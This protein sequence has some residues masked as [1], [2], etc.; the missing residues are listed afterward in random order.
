MLSGTQIT[1]PI[2][3]TQTVWIYDA[4]ATC[5]NEKSF[6]V[7]VNHTP[8]IINPGPQT[9]CDSYTFPTITG[10]NLTGGQKFYNNSKALNGTVI[11]GPIT[12]TQTIWIYDE[13][14]LCH[15]EKSFIVT[16]NYT[17][18]ITNP[19][20]QTVCDSYTLPTITGTHLSGNQKFYNNT[21]A[22]GGTV[23]TGPI[24]TTQTIWIYDANASCS[25][26]ESFVVTVNHTPNIT[27]PG[28]IT[29]CDTYTLP[30]ITGI[31]LTGN[32]KF[33]SNS[34]ALSGTA[35][36]GPITSTQ[37]IWI[38]DIQG[39]CKDEKSF[40][41][42]VNYTPTIT[43]T[44]SQI[45]CDSYTLPT[46]TGTHLSGSQ[47]YY[48][49]SQALSGTV[50]T[51]PITTTQ[52]VWIYDNNGTCKDEKSFSI[53][54]NKTPNITQPQNITVCDSY[55]LPAILGTNLSGNEKYYNNSQTLGGVPISGAIITTQTVW[56]YD[57]N[58]ACKNEKS[59]T[60]SIDYTPNMFNTG[61]QIVCDSYTLPLITGTNLTGNQKY[62]S[63][64]QAL[65][66]TPITGPITSTQPVWI[67]DA[68]GACKDEKSFI[69]TVNYT[70]FI[71]NPGNQ[72]VCDSYTLNAITGAHLS[73]NQKYYNNSK[74]LGGT[75]ITGVLTNTQT[76]WMY[77]QNGTCTNEKSF[78]LTVY[79]TPSINNPGNITVCD[80]YMLPVITGT[81]LTGAQKFYT[82]SQANSGMPLSGSITSNQTVWIYD[83]DG[84]CFDEKSFIVTVNHTPLI[85]NP[86]NQTVCDSYTLPTITG[87]NLNGSQKYYNNSQTS[88]GTVITGPITTTQ[89]VWMYDI[90]GACKDEKSF[91]ITINKTPIFS[92]PGDQTVCDTY[93]LPSFI[94]TYLSGNQNYF[95]NSQTNGGLV[96]NGP[97][98][99]TQTIW[100]YDANAACKNE[101][102]FIITVNHTPSLIN[103]G[104][105]TVCDIY[106]LPTITG[107]NLS[108][109][110]KYYNNSNLLNGSPINGPITLTQTIWIY[111]AQGSCSDEK[112]FIIT[113]NHT[114]N[115]TNPGNIT[116]C[117]SYLLTPISGTNLTGNQKYFNNSQVLGGTPITGL[118]TTTQKVWMYD[119]DA[120]CKD[121]KSFDITVNI[122][123]TINFTPDKTKGCVPLT[124]KFKNSTTPSSDN[125]VWDFGDGNTF[126]SSQL[127]DE[128]THE[129]TTVDCF[130]IKL[131]VTS[132]GCTN[133]LKTKDLI[134]TYSIPKASFNVDQERVSFLSPEV[135]C[136][137]TT[138]SATSYN[139]Y[140]GDGTESKEIN[141][142]H[143][144][145]GEKGTMQIILIAKNSFGCA[146]TA[147]RKIEIYDELIFYIPNTFTPDEDKYN[148]VFTPIFNAGYDPQNFTMYVFD[149]WGEIV[150][151]T[152]DSSIGW[153]G[154]LGK[155]EKMKCQDGL[156]IWKISYKENKTG[157]TKTVVGDVIL[158]R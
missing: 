90:D 39:L 154:L 152:H 73:G 32:E 81:N 22:S 105:Q 4:N 157:N 30:T 140:F 150:F 19:G 69:V 147:E 27:N 109:N 143:E 18:S 141:P 60:V 104:N 79:H 21:Q 15:D 85:N 145:P 122:T 65:S 70:P 49:N 33:Y 63:N 77:D 12:T 35:I 6:L 72:T 31:N 87:T 41:V 61:A 58:G 113:V 133:F 37:T 149:R 135:K 125:V 67:Y 137:N 38:Y 117:D 64:S 44:G 71:N 158:M 114:P 80:S 36:L 50:I 124:V 40:V 102:S 142:T 59:F 24:T 155:E 88:G 94:G 25:D 8:S 68:D 126:T 51:G 29:V 45:A 55:T 131:T 97:I 53:T 99:Q 132:N 95:T 28:N 78:L 76:V 153:Q 48:S 62:Y 66:G 134:C 13:Q 103:T 91:T 89:T 111:D 26:E 14:G 110:E 136:T 42:T 130:D 82:N 46:I 98:T 119:I 123:P 16:I 148:Q 34:Q 5:T 112:S 93:T 129:F 3:S 118:I 146:D 75:V 74:A 101:K 1:G 7:T 86:G 108:G 9:V 156:Y 100:M 10:T 127:K 115:L 2:T 17:P 47:K 52:T 54:I 83:K 57:N 121:E 128:I 11:T 20:P 139:W 116:V 106:N 56:V 96:V 84:I 120:A 43:N 151:E 107:T 92:T 144:F 23:I 138:L